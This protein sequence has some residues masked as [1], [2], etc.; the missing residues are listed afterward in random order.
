[1]GKVSTYKD[2]IVWQKAMEVAED[3]YPIVKKL[4]REETYALGDQMRRAAV[5]VPSNIA[6]GFGRNSKKEYIQFL[7]IANGSVCELET[8]LILCVRFK[9]LTEQEILPII[10]LLDEI[11]K[12]IMTI[13]KKLSDNTSTSK[14]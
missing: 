4:P 5:S 6:E 14:F 12:I 7:F 10:N 9:Y 11:K 2:L 13:T 3:L 8:Q 1:M